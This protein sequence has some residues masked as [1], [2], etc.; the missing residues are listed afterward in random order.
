MNNGV[1]ITDGLGSF[2]CRCP[3]GTTGRT[4]DFRMFDLELIPLI[5][6]LL[7]FVFFL[8]L[9]VTQPTNPC[10]PNPCLY[11]GQ[12]TPVG[13]GYSCVCPPQYT[14]PNCATPLTQAPSNK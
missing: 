5:V 10:S 13:N 2:S 14:G 1:C 12:C 4:C 9:A 8:Y 11:G 3:P 6:S 7:K